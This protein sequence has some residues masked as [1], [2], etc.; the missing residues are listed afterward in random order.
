[1]YQEMLASV[2]RKIVY[3]LFLVP[4][5][6]LRKRSRR[7]HL[8]ASHQNPAAPRNL[9]ASAG[10][11][12]SIEKSRP[13]TSKKLPGRNDPCWC[14]SGKKYKNCHLRADQRQAA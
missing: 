10:D 9:R 4:K 5:E 6:M 13:H 2:Q 11:V 1:M 12:P 14:G 8:V 7:S 3:S